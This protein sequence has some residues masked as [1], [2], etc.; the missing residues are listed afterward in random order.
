M[1]SIVS[2]KHDSLLDAL[3]CTSGR[4][5]Y[6]SMDCFEK[7][8]IFGANS[9]SLYVYSLAT[10]RVVQMCSFVEIKQAVQKVLFIKKSFNSL[11]N[12][13]LVCCQRASFVV[14]LCLTSAGNDQSSSSSSVSGSSTT[15]T[16]STTTTASSTS[17]TTS[18]L[19]NTSNQF[20]LFKAKPR[21]VARLEQ[22]H[23]A[24]IIDVV[25]GTSLDTN[26]STAFYFGDS[27]GNVY[28]SVSFNIVLDMYIAL[29][30]LRL[31]S[32]TG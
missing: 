25:V 7:Y 2:L 29:V 11:N 13:A 15:T 6:T 12:F 30:S 24:A 26:A 10:M 21:V 23:G 18:T 3:S 1:S 20:G 8:M 5:K 17:S 16:T 9:G 32:T 27:N 4:V 28:V 14:D 31:A 19:L 22:A